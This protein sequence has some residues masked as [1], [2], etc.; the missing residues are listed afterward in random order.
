MVLTENQLRPKDTNRMK[1]KGVK[2]IVVTKEETVVT[3]GVS[4]N[5]DFKLISATRDRKGVSPIDKLV[6]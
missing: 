1:V 2:K 4:D 3:I 6:N 5:I